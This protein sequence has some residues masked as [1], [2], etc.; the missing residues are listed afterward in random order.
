MK[1]PSAVFSLLLAASLLAT[2][3]Q[4]YAIRRAEAGFS[5]APGHALLERAPIPCNQ[6]RG[7]EDEVSQV[8]STGSKGTAYA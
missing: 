4:A 3:G 8:V 1:T 6:P 7:L 2:D 5:E